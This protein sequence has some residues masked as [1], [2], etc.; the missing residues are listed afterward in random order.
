MVK[1]KKMVKNGKKCPYSEFFLS[2]FSGIWT[3]YADLLYKSLY[4]VRMG[5]NTD[6]KNS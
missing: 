1:S 5:E 2:I 3:E 6:D 4:S